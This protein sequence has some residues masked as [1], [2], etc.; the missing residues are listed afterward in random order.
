MAPFVEKETEQDGP[1]GHRSSCRF[2][3]VILRALKV[4][5]VLTHKLRA[6]RFNATLEKQ[7]INTKKSSTINPEWQEEK[8]I[9]FVCKTARG[10][11]PRGA[12]AGIQ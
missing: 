10:C 4:S 5:E 6:G 12:P 1:G 11:P 8:G 9:V 3:L 7:Q 2:L